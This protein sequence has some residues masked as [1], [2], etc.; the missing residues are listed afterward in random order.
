MRSLQNVKLILF[1]HALEFVNS[2][3]RARLIIYLRINKKRSYEISEECHR[4]WDGDWGNPELNYDMGEALYKA[5]EAFLTNDVPT[6]W[7]HIGKALEE[8]IYKNDQQDEKWW[9]GMLK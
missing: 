1:G 4:L 5:A 8:A 7:N 9:E 6:S 3:E 2:D